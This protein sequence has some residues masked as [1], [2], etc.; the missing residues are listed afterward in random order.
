M[1]FPTSAWSAQPNPELVSDST[2]LDSPEPDR[3]SWRLGGWLLFAEILGLALVVVGVLFKI[4]SWSWANEILLF[5]MVVVLV[6][7]G[8]LLPIREARYGGWVILLAALACSTAIVG[9][10]FIILSW[11]GG[12][13]MLQA[14]VVLGAIAMAAVVATRVTG[15]KPQG[16]FAWWMVR[17]L[18]Y[19][20]SAAGAISRI[21]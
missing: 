8:I 20:L 21:L 10:Q 13:I 11:A 9:R 12:T 19:C 14:G 7:V 15:G 4:L 6:V 3:Q 5:G 16:L 2:L 17:L 1:G 18:L